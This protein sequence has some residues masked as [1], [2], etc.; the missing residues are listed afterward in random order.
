MA[1]EQVGPPKAVTLPAARWGA[2]EPGDLTFH[3]GRQLCP[4]LHSHS[5]DAP[6]E[7]VEGDA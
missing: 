1:H 4:S 6:Q 3:L 5:N 2:R 7:E